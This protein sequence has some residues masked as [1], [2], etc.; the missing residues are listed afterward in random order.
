M[1]EKNNAVAAQRGTVHQATVQQKM[2]QLADLV[3]W[4]QSPHFSLEE[5]VNHYKQAEQ[6]AEEIQADLTGLK[7][8]IKV[9]KRQFE[10]KDEDGA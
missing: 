2:N 6:L 9:I 5:A 4:F 1:S 10:H 7:N 3:T 8:D